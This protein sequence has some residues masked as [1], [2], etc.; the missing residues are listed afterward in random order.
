MKNLFA[1]AAVCA[2]LSG[3]AM[4]QTQPAAP[5]GEAAETEAAEPVDVDAAV[6]AINDIATDEKKAAGYCEISKE[7]SALSE[8][9]DAK[10][11]E[12]GKK[13]DAYLTGLGEEYVEA[14]DAAES[15]DPETEDGKK[16]D[17]A[18]TALEAKCAA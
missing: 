9:D 16:L 6:K 14:F 10:G 18:F 5:A 8:T 1:L 2:L 11:E 13:L 12:L 17:T 15:L 3:P 4:A 7:L